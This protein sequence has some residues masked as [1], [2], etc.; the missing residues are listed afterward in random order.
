[1]L[2]VEESVVISKPRQEVWEFLADPANVTLYSSNISEYELTS[3]APTEVG[4]T[5]RIVVK[6]AGI[7]LESTDE[8][9]EIDEGRMFKLESRDAKVP[10][11]LTMT[12]SDE[13]GGTRLT[14][15]QEAESLKGVFKFGDS[16]VTKMYA[17][18]VRGN[19]ENAKTLIEG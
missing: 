17:H 11:T 4:R 1:M 13:G 18:D 15:L 10:Y 12:L 6:V 14:W 3:G 2:K 5:A 9:V 16:I 19:L 8:L 7:R